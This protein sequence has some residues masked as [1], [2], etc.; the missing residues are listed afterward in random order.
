MVILSTTI[1]DIYKDLLKAPK[2]HPIVTII[3]K[4]R[5]YE[6]IQASLASLHSMLYNIKDYATNIDAMAKSPGTKKT[7]FNCGLHHTFK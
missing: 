5:E 1:E 3:T 4:G 7:F 2:E 6:A